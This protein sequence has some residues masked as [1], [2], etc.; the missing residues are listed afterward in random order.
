MSALNIGG[1]HVAYVEQG[2]GEPVIL[3]HSSA[4]SSA[5]WRGL[6]DLLSGRFR[7]VA[8]DLYGYGATASWPGR[9]PFALEHEAEIVHALLGRFEEPAHLVGH[10]Y[11]G[12]VALH[13][14]RTRADLLRSLTLIEPVAFH[15]L[16][17]SGALD[18]LAFSEISEVAAKVWTAVQ[19]G[20]YAGGCASFVEYWS[21]PGAW[22]AIPAAKRDAM[23][24]RLAKVALD[25]HATLNEPAGL[26]DFRLMAL[27]TLVLQGACSPLPTRR[28]CERLAGALPESSF[29]I[30]EGAGHM[31]PLT[32]RDE[33]NRLVA[34]HLAST[35]S[36]PLI[37]GTSHASHAI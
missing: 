25:F 12:A 6:M 1:T 11:G 22:A 13:V 36:Y 7:V 32:H 9:A 4:G 21:G 10:S 24:A 8:A 14:A 37:K 34:T 16:R 30:V 19:C 5:Q 3:L 2:T 31:L 27:P 35:P 26:D 28:I 15:L 20:N 23:A 29:E 17:Y 33:V 18:A